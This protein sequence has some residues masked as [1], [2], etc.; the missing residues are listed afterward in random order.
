MDS[1]EADVLERIK[2]FASEMVLN[3]DWENPGDRYKTAVNLFWEHY[4]NGKPI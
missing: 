3:V 4:L 1:M 2:E